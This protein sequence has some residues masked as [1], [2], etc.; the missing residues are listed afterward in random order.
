MSETPNWLHFAAE[1]LQVA[2][3]T[4]EAG[5]YNQTCFHAQQCVE[6]ALKAWPAHHGHAP[7]RVHQMSLLLRLCPRPLPFPETLE[8]SILT[9]DRFY[10]PTRYPDALPGTLSDLATSK[11]D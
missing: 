8:A 2:E 4:L 11:E 5:I 1:D 7:P 3:L 6:K 9:L 10:I